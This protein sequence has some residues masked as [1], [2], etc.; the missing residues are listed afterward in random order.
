MMDEVRCKRCKRLL[1][2]G[3]IK[4]AMLRIKCPRCKYLNV[5]AFKKEFG[6]QIFESGGQ[7]VTVSL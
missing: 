4:E 6:V 7:R 2:E 3:N 1:L 5:F